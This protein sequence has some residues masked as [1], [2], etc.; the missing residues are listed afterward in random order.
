ME[1]EWDELEDIDYGDNCGG[2][3]A[4][5]NRKFNESNSECQK[6]LDE[7]NEIEDE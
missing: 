2:P 3:N 4:C 5:Q 7:A 6:C 1:I